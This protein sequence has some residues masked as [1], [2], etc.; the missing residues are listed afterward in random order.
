MLRLDSIQRMTMYE[1]G[2]GCKK[3]VRA[4]YTVEDPLDVMTNGMFFDDVV[5]IPFLSISLSS[6][7]GTTTPST[8]SLVGLPGVLLPPSLALVISPNQGMDPSSPPP[9]GLFLTQRVNGMKL[10]WCFDSRNE[11]KMTKQREMRCKEANSYSLYI[12]K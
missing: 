10:M 1:D 5:S 2:V 12:F 11:N 9:Y 8:P 3:L 6:V 4:Q 7:D